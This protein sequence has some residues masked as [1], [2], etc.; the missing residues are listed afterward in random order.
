MV[1]LVHFRKR[2]VREVSKKRDKRERQEMRDK[3]EFKSSG[4]VGYEKDRLPPSRVKL[5]PDR[6][7]N[8]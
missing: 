6:G 3:R 5:P 7:E 1:Y 8:E 2:E 4:S